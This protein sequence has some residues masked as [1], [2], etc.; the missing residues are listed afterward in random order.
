MTRIVP[1]ALISLALVGAIR[2]Q[3]APTAQSPA[4]PDAGTVGE[5]KYT[6]TF[7]GFT[8]TLPQGTSL[9]NESLPFNDPRKKFL[10]GLKGQDHGF[11][12]FIVTAVVAESASSDDAKREVSDARAGPPNK[13]RIA[14]KDFW[15]TEYQD[16]SPAGKMQSVEYATPLG[17]YVLK[18]A[19]FS[20]DPKV[21]AEFEHT[22][23]SI[24]FF[25][26]AKGKSGAGAQPANQLLA[27]AE[28]T[29]S[30]NSCVEALPPASGVRC[31]PA[32]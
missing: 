9:H 16:K 22:V 15:R 25:D 23:E 26:P 1:L 30:V 12:S 6:N 2:T 19:I 31:L 7:F 32:R 24:S 3:S 8:I 18:F 13:V 4:S 29:S 27:I 21:T 17:G 14:G 10:F 5:G 11:A 20:F 28:I